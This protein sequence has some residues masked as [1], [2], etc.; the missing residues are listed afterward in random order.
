M[1]SQAEES[2]SGRRPMIPRVM[3]LLRHQKREELT[4]QESS[5]V[6][7]GQRTSVFRASRYYNRPQRLPAM[8]PF[9]MPSPQFD[10]RLGTTHS[11][12]LL[13]SRSDGTNRGVHTASALP[14]L[15]GFRVRPYA[16]FLR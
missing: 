14:L 3:C 13:E 10:K 7:A 15:G 9:C 5:L 6:V 11:G 8:R 16:Q 2:L 1:R 4:V 12:R